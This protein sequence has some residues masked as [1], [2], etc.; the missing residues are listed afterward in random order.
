MPETE[1]TCVRCAREPRDEDDRTSWASI[2]QEDVCP[3][4]LTL[5]EAD[6]LRK[7]LP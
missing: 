7:E 4:C 3:G 5:S 1:V 6:A 2:D